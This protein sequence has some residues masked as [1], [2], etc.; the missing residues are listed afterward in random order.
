MVSSSPFY[1]FLL[2]IV[3]RVEVFSDSLCE[4]KT[5]TR[6]VS[7]EAEFDVLNQCLFSPV[8]RLLAQSDCHR[9][10]FC[11]QWRRRRPLRGSQKRSKWSSS[12]QLMNWKAGNS[13][14]CGGRGSR[15]QLRRAQKSLMRCALHFRK[16]AGTD[17]TDDVDSLLSAA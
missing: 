17:G 9:D 13:V 5:A 14:A 15:V 8:A 12:I 2:C 11:H 1:C 7:G 10:E 4:V 16:S 6:Q 3:S